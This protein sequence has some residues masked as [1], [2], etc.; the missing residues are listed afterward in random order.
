VTASA[1]QRGFTNQRPLALILLVLILL[2]AFGTRVHDL[3][4]Q[5]MWN[6]EGLSVF[7]A[8][9]S[10]GTVAGNII[11]IDGADTRDTNPP[12]YFL[13]LHGW[14][15]LAGDSVFALRYLGLLLAV[16]SVPLIFRLGALTFGRG[17]GLVAAFFLAL[18]PFHVWQSQEMRNY[19]LLLFFNLAAVLGLVRFLKGHAVG[20]RWRWLLLW[21]LSSL[22]GIYTHYFGFFVFAFGVLALTVLGLRGRLSRLSPR[23]LALFA[24]LV[25]VGI[26]TLLT[27][28]TR[29]QG[30]TQV[31]FAYVPPHHLLSH[32]ASVYA[33]GIVPDVVQPLW[34]V[35]PALLLA[36][37]GILLAWHL[38]VRAAL[39]LILGYLS[40]PLV[41]LMTLS[42][43]NPLYNGPRHLLMGLPPFILLVAAGIALPWKV[44]RPVKRPLAG[45]AAALALL[46]TGSQGQWLQTQY[47]DEAL[48]KDD[49]RGLAEYLSQA[50]SKD[51]LVVVHDAI[52]GLTFDYYYRGDAPWMAVPVFW[53]QDQKAAIKRLQ[54]A[55]VT[56]Q[57]IYFVTEPEPRTGFPRQALTT[58]A[59][60]NWTGLESRRFPALWLHVNLEVFVPNPLVAGLPEGVDAL[61]ALW[62]DELLL[63]GYDAADNAQAGSFWGP[64]FYWAKNR[65]VA[66]NYSLSLRLVDGRDQIWFQEDWPLWQSYPPS[67]WP[68]GSWIRYQPALA[69][70]AGLPPGNYRLRLRVTDQTDKRP[71]LTGGQDDLLL[72]GSLSIRPALSPAALDRL[73][74]HEKV[75]RTFGGQV[76]LVGYQ[77]PVAEI[78]P[79]QSLPIDLFWR[80]RRSPESDLLLTVQLLDKQGQLLTEISTVPSLPTYSPS[81]WKQDELLLGRVGLV[82]PA[83]AGAGDVT[84]LVGLFVPET[85]RLLRAG[86]FLGPKMIEL[87]S[88]LVVPWPLVTELPA[89]GQPL[90][91]DFG[92]PA[93]IELHGYDLSATEIAA[94]ESLDLTLTWRSAG[95]ELLLGYKVFVHLAN[96]GEEIVAQADGVPV[97]GFRPTTGWR[98]G[99]VIVDNYQI[100][101]P[102]GTA[103]GPYRLWI[104]LYDP[105][106]NIR[107]PL[108]SGDQ[109]LLDD[110]LDLTEVTIRP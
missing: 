18:S 36:L 42:T 88:T 101:V 87:G 84:V 29:F 8:R 44:G 3:D 49:I 4:G 79:G 22:L 33:A 10:L 2:L 54:A 16:L 93:S 13:L 1:T 107:L 99:E 37:A 6:D 89:I 57:R 24:L 65:S 50:T 95:S 86:W 98:Q 7:R 67:D 48:R 39:L 91:A 11:T 32:A 28:L 30:D 77:M 109:R 70:P 47:T 40:I 94:G 102:S 104:G 62:G 46:L 17:A 34:R 20:G 38:K 5:S 43:I 97:S 21:A 68:E 105:A 92:Q 45:I 78:R 63:G 110:R 61:D 69:L 41:T 9:Q 75:G 51:D 60:E 74:T 66:G 14:L 71:L 59:A 53:Q 55:G 56:A 72:P 81:R 12:L 58:W 35:A 25:L 103:A 83:T 80:V 76:E 106:T 52:I 82:I 73:P 26:P 31:D 64:T 108:Y 27:A 90:R 96:E 19:S 15:R 23:L 85:G 100:A